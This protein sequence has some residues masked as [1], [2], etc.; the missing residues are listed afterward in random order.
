M[1]GEK[2]VVY[3]KCLC[4]CGY[5]REVSAGD[6]ILCADCNNDECKMKQKFEKMNRI[7]WGKRNEEIPQEKNRKRLVSFM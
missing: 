5:F 7:V 1:A 2:Y 4:E 6:L 3:C